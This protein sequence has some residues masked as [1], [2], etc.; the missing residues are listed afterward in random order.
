MSR[1]SEDDLG[2]AQVSGA[3]EVKFTSIPCFLMFN[4]FLFVED[5]VCFEG[6]ATIGTPSDRSIANCAE[7]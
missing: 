3:G 6:C 4:L 1:Q 7:N 5:S 2:E